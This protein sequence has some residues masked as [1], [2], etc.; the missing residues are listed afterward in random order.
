MVQGVMGR[1]KRK[2]QTI[3]SN[4]VFPNTILRAHTDSY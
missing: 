1:Q 2:A 3:G 4:Q